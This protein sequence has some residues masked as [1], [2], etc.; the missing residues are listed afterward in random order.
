MVQRVAT[1]PQPNEA[2]ANTR[3]GTQRVLLRSSLVRYG[4]ALIALF[5]FSFAIVVLL[6]EISFIVVFTISTGIALIPALFAQVFLARGRMVA[7]TFLRSFISHSLFAYVFLFTVVSI[8]AAGPY[9]SAVPPVLVFV[10]AVALRRFG[11]IVTRKGTVS[12]V[13]VGLVANRLSSALFLF[14]L[15]QLTV[16]AF[17]VQFLGYPFLYASIACAIFST[18]PLIAFSESTKR[19]REAGHYLLRSSAKWTV[20]AFLVGVASAILSYPGA[21]AYTYLAVL[22]LT[23]VV[24]GYVGIRIYSLGASQLQRIQQDIYKKHAHEIVLVN[25][26]SFDYLRQAIEEFVKTGK[27]ERLIIALTGLLTNAGLDYGEINN[28][29][30]LLTS[31]EIPP[32]FRSSYLSMA[33]SLEVELQKRLGIV[34]VLLKSLAQK[35]SSVQRI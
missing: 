14:L 5:I 3:D 9:T 13:P 2:S 33:H 20:V 7:A 29:L 10:N 4:I 18:A 16:F 31:Y 6:P 27:N 23:G 1:S 17:Q 25:D 30:S 22:V 28:Q 12:K 8:P 11:G 15:Y 32:I 19:Y 21:S 34:Q 24:V 35:T 26:E